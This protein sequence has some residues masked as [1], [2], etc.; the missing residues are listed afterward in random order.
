MTHP[1]FDTSFLVDLIE[2]LAHRLSFLAKRK[3]SLPSEMKNSKRREK[4]EV[5]AS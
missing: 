1:G 5:S 4:D 2:V 3:S